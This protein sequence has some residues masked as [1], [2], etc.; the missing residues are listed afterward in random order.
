MT[1]TKP[2]VLII[3]AGFGG[4]AAARRLRNVPVEVI[5]LDRTNHHLFQP[6]LYQVATAGLSPAQIAAPIRRLLRNQENTRVLLGEALRQP[7]FTEDAFER[8]RA[9]RRAAPPTSSRS[10]RRGGCGS[11]STAVRGR[12][13]ATNRS[14]SIR[15]STSSTFKPSA[16][17]S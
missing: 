2:R 6:L 3:G 9:S 14:R 8:I 11:S 5:V 7:E 16:C 4:L 17:R 15:P 1:D 10:N 13:L 12:F